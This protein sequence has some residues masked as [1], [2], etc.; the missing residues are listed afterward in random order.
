MED[1]ESIVSDL[2]ELLFFLAFECYTEDKERQDKIVRMA[3]GLRNA[4]DALE[5]KKE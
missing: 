5:G 1:K 3:T 4:I 2:T